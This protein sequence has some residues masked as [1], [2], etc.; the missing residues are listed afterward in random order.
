MDACDLS[1]RGLFVAMAMA[2]MISGTVPV[3]TLTAAEPVVLEAPLTESLPPPAPPAT[4]EMEL[5]A[6][7]DPSAGGVVAPGDLALESPRS[8]ILPA[9]DAASPAIVNEEYQPEDGLIVPLSEQPLAGVADL[10][11]PTLGD[12][13]GYDTATGD[14]AWL[15]G[16]NDHFG[17]T[18]LESFATLPQ[19]IA[20]GLVTGI[21]FHF[22]DGPIQTDM[23]ARLFDFSLGYQ[24]RHWIWP[25]VGL[26]TVV[27]VGAFGDFEG[28]VRNGVRFPGHAVA[29]FRM[30]RAYE[31]LFGIDELDRD[32]ISL[33]PVFGAVWKPSNN[34]RIDAV[35][36]RPSAAIRIGESDDWA[37][38]RGYLG[39]GT[40][41]IE[42]TDLT[43][44]NA[45][46]RDLRLALGVEIHDRDSIR[47]SFE[48]GYVFA[49]E[50]SF[51]S[52]RG[53]FDVGDVIMIGLNNSY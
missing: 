35:F 23:P 33:L 53:D 22:L 30:T 51:R 18:S 34:L 29:F 46:Y 42:R 19:S 17:V 21:A 47:S 25:N 43:D 16:H 5:D 24:L 40:W 32:D 28:S 50:L 9:P 3:A 37:Y 41:A 31:L 11:P 48:V 7:A 15:I 10:S 38:V 49:R 13:F 20:H 14:T 36:P 8:E 26:D 45:T 12:A 39:G 4:A 2:L 1:I 27:R 44:D 6:P 52:G